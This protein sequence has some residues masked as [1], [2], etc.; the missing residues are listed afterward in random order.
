MNGPEN[1]MRS[2]LS[3]VVAARP[4]R[5][6]AGRAFVF[7]H[8]G[9]IM[10]WVRMLALFLPWSWSVWGGERDVIINEIMYHPPDDREDL[11]YVELFNRGS[12]SVDLAGWSFTKGIRF[13]FPSNTKMD[14]GAYLVVSRSQTAFVAHYGKELPVVGNFS[15][16]LSHQGDR[17][18]LCNAPKKVIDAVKYS[19][20]GEWP[21]G[22]DG[23]SA[24]LERICPVGDSQR[25]DNWAGSKLP[26]FRSA[27]GTPGQ[28]ND[29]HSPILP[30]SIGP[31][32]G[33][34]R[35][36]SPGQKVAISVNVADPE[37]VKSVTLFYRVA[38]PGK[39]TAETPILMERKSGD[40]RQGHYQAVLEGR[41][42]GQLVR[43]RIQA[44]SRA[45]IT[46]TQ[47][48]ENEPRP[49]YSYYSMTNTNTARIPFGYV[50]S[51]GQPEKRVGRWTVNPRSGRGGSEPTRG[52]AAFI[53][54]PPNGGEAITFD[55]V[56]VV[57]R[58]GGLKIH[59]QKDQPLNGMTTINLIFEGS[60]RW[61]LSEPLAY[62]VY[63]RAG[64]PAPLTD[65]VRLWTDGRPRGYYL[66]IEQPNKSFLARNK[67]DDSG[68]L[69]KLLWYGQGVVGQHEKKSNL[70]TGH[71]DLVQVI[72][73]LNRKSGPEQW[74][75]IQQHFHVEE[76]INYFAV[77]MCIQNWDGFFNN[78]YAYH[79]LRGTNKWE[80]Y[81]WDEDKTWGDYDGAS[82]RYD[83]YEMPLTFGMKGDNGPRSVWS[84]FG[85]GPFGGVN[86]W[87]PPGYF[88]GPLLANPEFRKRFLARLREI[89]L[90]VF[91]EEKLLPV[92]AEMEKRLAPEMHFR[93]EVHGEDAQQSLRVFRSHMESFRAQVQN[94]R[95]FILGELGGTR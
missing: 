54:V 71:E 56:R 39:E 91:T 37:G 43:F 15:G 95:K 64:V 32:E 80:V 33:L 38:T 28:K 6:R 47:P 78:Y 41:P 61:V 2:E 4:R 85:G 16:K 63:R 79:D 35:I 13:V 68:N 88:S 84:L 29:S 27:A 23:N 10:G 55:H 11:Q 62:E 17:L 20:R 72:D 12:N 21:T 24:A 9:R 90:T 66:L 31:I 7:S 46:R 74:A 42:A 34:P 94:R 19:D 69:Y 75:F 82:S 93:A 81:P 18:E 3:H 25:A 76:V 22:P 50:I 58:N 67:R 14:A 5:V 65:H 36:A 30:P 83:W 53:Y 49:A 45:E 8:W 59:F 73:G 89:C 87:R 92:I 51:V 48:A 77:N 26:P 40:E 57:P 86:W 60:P 1:Q 70:T 52:Q 44:V